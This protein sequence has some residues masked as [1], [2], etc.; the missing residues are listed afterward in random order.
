MGTNGWSAFAA[1]STVEDCKTYCLNFTGE[2]ESTCS[3]ITFVTH[4]EHGNMCW[5]G[6]E[7]ETKAATNDLY[8]GGPHTG[9]NDIEAFN[10]A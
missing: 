8:T 9:S 1:A 2:D 6:M 7:D 3:R 10:Y 4:A 5:M